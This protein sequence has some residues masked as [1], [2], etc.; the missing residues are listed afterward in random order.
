MHV[1]VFAKGLEDSEFSINGSYYYYY[2]FTWKTSI[3]YYKYGY[4]K[5]QCTHIVL[6]NKEVDKNSCYK[7][8]GI[9]ICEVVSLY[10]FSLILL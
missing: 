6:D 7:N 3:L 2:D 5:Y 9:F 8:E 4:Q 10:I 1:T